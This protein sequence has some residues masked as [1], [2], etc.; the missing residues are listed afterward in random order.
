MGNSYARFSSENA[1]LLSGD[2]EVLS[3]VEFGYPERYLTSSGETAVAWEPGGN[4][5][6]LGAGGARL[7]KAEGRLL[8]VFGSDTGAVSALV[9]DGGE[10]KAE[11]FAAP[12]VKLELSPGNRPIAAVIGG[13]GSVLA[14][15]SPERDGF[16]VSAYSLPDMSPACVRRWTGRSTI[17]NGRTPLCFAL[18]AATERYTYRRGSRGRCCRAAQIKRRTGPCI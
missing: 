9:E 11:I 12:G 17:W 8:G 2:G 15:L 7:E 4:I 6:F 16:Y 1:E 14:L 18:S 13:R 3:A 5:A 10:V